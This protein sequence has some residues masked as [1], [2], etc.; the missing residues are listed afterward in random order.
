MIS[1]TIRSLPKE[2]PFWTA[3]GL[4]FSFA[5]VLV[6][7]KASET[8]PESWAR[9]CPGQQDDM[10]IFVARRRPDSWNWA[11]PQTD[12]DLMSGVGAKGSQSR[13]GDDTFETLLMMG[14]DGGDLTMF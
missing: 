12:Q 13:K 9:F 1:Y 6:R 8:A 7:S 3:F 11:V 4:W 10:F 2:A 5:P 14:L